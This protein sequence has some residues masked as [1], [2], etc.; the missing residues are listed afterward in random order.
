[1][2]KLKNIAASLALLAGSTAAVPALAGIH[3]DGLQGGGALGGN[4]FADPNFDPTN[5]S[6]GGVGELF[7]SIVARDAANPVNNRSYARDLGLTSRTFV[8]AL[9]GGTLGSLAFSFGPDAALNGF[10]A[11]NTGKDIRFLVMAV[12]NPSGFDPMTGAG[13]NIGFVTTSAVD[14]ATV[15][16]QQ[17]QGIPGFQVSGA[18]VEYRGFVGGVNLKTDGSPVGNTAANLS[19]VFQPGEGGFHDLN[20]GRDQTFGF[21]TEGGLGTAVDFFFISADDTDNSFSVA[22]ALLGKWTLSVDGNLA[23]APVPVP[24]AAWLMGSAVAGL[25]GIARR[26]RV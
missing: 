10:L 1:M 6:I 8:D 11:A 17:P 16:A 12:H 25:A 14:A 9:E 24:A 20:F 3:L 18:E 15:A 22:P 2:M 19:A 13:H 21:N 23:F 4:I 7:V 5:Y 26:R